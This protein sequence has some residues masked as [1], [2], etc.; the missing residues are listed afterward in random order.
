M[1]APQLRTPYKAKPIPWI[2][3]EDLPFGESN[4]LLC[5]QKVCPCLFFF[6]NAQRERL[7]PNDEY[8]A[9]KAGPQLNPTLPTSGRGG[10]LLLS[11]VLRLKEGGKAGAARLIM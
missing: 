9:H 8:H 3:I 4:E 5:W 11:Q 1:L 2:R 10:S 6:S 7:K